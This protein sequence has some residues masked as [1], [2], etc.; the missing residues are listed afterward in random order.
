MEL[1]TAELI[2]R[3]ERTVDGIN[4]PIRAIVRM[5]DRDA[6]VILKELAPTLL[7]AECFAALLL[8]GWGLNV[9]EPV[10]VHDHEEKNYFGSLEVNYPSLKQSMGFNNLAE[11][12]R[13]QIYPHMAKIAAQWKQTPLCIATDEIIGNKDRNIGNILW[14]GGDPWFI[15]H[16]RS[17]DL[18]EQDDLNKMVELILLSDTPKAIQTSA[19]AII[20]TLLPSII[21]EA[22]QATAALDTAKFNAYI[23]SRTPG[24]ASQVI[25]RFPQPDDLLS[26]KT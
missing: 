2:H 6:V 1:L 24:W 11:N 10:L 13:A 26:V 25:K 15:D 19:V 14:D 18:L 20:F 5:A 12:I 3:G 23:K 16:E 9:P 8:R 21:D 4:S 7:A 17:F 22:E